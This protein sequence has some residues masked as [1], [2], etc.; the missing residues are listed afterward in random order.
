MTATGG[1]FISYMT[2]SPL[3]SIEFSY[4]A[5]TMTARIGHKSRTVKIT[6][7]QALELDSMHSNE[8]MRAAHVFAEA[9]GQL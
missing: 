9:G 6:E 5:T 7:E 8:Q 4:T 2:G 1:T 3:V